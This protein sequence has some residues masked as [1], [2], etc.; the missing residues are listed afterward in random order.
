[1]QEKSN[2]SKT[3]KM[4]ILFDHYIDHLELTEKTLLETTDETIESVHGKF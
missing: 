2:V 3:L 1:M 4:L